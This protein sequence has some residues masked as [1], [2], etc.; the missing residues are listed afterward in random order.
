MG[1]S[2]SKT[3][4]FKVTALAII[5]GVVLILAGHPHEGSSLLSAAVLGYTVSRGLAKK[6]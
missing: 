3:S 2:G 4:E 6:E 5:G 1:R